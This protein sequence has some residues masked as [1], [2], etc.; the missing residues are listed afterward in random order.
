MLAARAHGHDYLPGNVT[1]AGQ[2][3]KPTLSCG[4]SITQMTRDNRIVGTL[5][6]RRG[7]SS[8]YTYP[9]PNDWKVTR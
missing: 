1:A 4:N 8:G 9:N 7:Q 6:A 5:C 3:S 2:E